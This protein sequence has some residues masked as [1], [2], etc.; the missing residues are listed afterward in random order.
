MNYIN[1]LFNNYE[2]LKKVNYENIQEIIKSSDNNYIINTLD[3]NLQDV[4]IPK[5]ISYHEEE[6]II[7][8]LISKF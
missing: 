3:N 7:N 5:T 1:S 6:N 2:S 8:S 4:V